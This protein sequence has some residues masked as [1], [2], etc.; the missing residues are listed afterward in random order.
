[1]ENQPMG[2]PVKEQAIEVEN[3]EPLAQS[4]LQRDMQSGAISADGE[5]LVDDV[6]GNK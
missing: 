3:N 2:E 5:I 1:M 4:A 6:G